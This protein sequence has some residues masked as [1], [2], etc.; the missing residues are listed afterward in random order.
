MALIQWERGMVKV[1][2]KAKAREM[3][4]AI[5]VGNSGMGPGNVQATPKEGEK[6][7]GKVRAG[8]GQ[9]IL[10]MVKLKVKVLMVNAKVKVGGTK[11]HV[12]AATK[13]DKLIARQ[14]KVWIMDFTE[15]KGKRISARY[16]QLK[17]MRLSSDHALR[18]Y[19]SML[20]EI[21]IRSLL[22][23]L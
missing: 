15:S 16:S 2:G 10:V 9:T 7:K 11:V 1:L 12:S 20:N 18:K 21:K 19:V 6:E 3:V 23:K 17:P 13:L 14:E 22:A 5:F 8:R 4:V